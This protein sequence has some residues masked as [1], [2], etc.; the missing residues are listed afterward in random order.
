MFGVAGKVKCKS[1]GATA[2]QLLF[3]GF[4]W[5]AVLHPLYPGLPA[6][7]WDVAA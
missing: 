1:R 5:Q 4:W 2:T 7:Q 6:V 3:S